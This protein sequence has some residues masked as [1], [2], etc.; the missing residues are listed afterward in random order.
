[1]RKERSDELKGRVDG[2]SSLRGDISVRNMAAA[3]IDTNS[4]DVNTFSPL[5]RSYATLLD[6]PLMPRSVIDEI[7]VLSFAT[8]D[9]VQRSVHPTRTE[10]HLSSSGA[11]VLTF[12]TQEAGVTIRITETDAY[13]RTVESNVATS[14]GASSVKNVRIIIPEASGEKVGKN[15]SCSKLEE[16]LI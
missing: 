1:V 13:F 5:R 16:S 8:V 15:R 3:G 6:I 9:G 4:N 2:I 12:F 7:S 14:F 11:T 10:V